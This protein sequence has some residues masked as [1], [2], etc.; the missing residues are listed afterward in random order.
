V[1]F[2]QKVK[3][4]RIEEFRS[5]CDQKFELATLFKPVA[6]LEELRK[7]ALAAHEGL[8]KEEGEA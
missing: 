1:E 2:L 5:K 3:S 4:T 7:E 6:D 8:P